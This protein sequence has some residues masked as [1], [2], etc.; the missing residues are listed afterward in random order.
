MKNPGS[1]GPQRPAGPPHAHEGRD[2]LIRGAHVLSMDPA[3]GEWESADVLVREGRIAAVGPGLLAKGVPEIDGRAT[4][5]LPGFVDA[6]WH[7]WNSSL[8]GLVQ[9]DDAERGY[10]S[11]TLRLGPLYRPQDS[12]CAVRLGAM[13]GLASGITTVH[14]W[15]HNTL[16]PAHAAAEV[17]ALADLGVRARFSYGWGQ[18][19]A[20]DHPMDLAGLSAFAKAHPAGG[21]IGLG[22]A[23][24]TPVANPR[25]AVSVD[26]L[27]REFEVVRGL[28]LPITMHARPTIVPV[29]HQHGL[30]GPDLQLI[31][32][33]G[34]T[35]EDIAL[36]A[37]QGCSVSCSPLIEVHYAQA[38]RGVIQFQ[39]LEQAGVRQSLS[40]DSS[41]ASANADF[42]NCMRVLLF[43]HKQRFGAR[44]PL[45]PRRLLQLATL[46]GARDLGLDAVTGSLTPGKQADIQLVRLDALNMVPVS[47]PAH[48]LV[49]SAQPANVDTVMVDGRLQLHAGRF[50]RHDPARAMQEA[51]DSARA[52]AARAGMDTRLRQPPSEISTPTQGAKR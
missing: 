35:E 11:V 16:S 17:Q 22:A 8:R 24:R 33:Q 12:Y 26:A 25:G 21:L 23:L 51:V 45:T 5:A 10:F 46:D 49:Y 50:V 30:L 42:F 44:V 41:S 14:D 29:L 40:V 31:H 15:S 18:G 37:G 32:P 27:A 19:H 6:H 1:T 34:F 39:E 47:D 52:L 7:L 4:V 9:G 20:L 3:V 2:W 28:G 38:M 48:A 13:E 43:S 36:L